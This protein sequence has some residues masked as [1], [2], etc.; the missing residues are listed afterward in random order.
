VQFYRHDVASTVKSFAWYVLSAVS[1]LDSMHAAA[2]QA[3][4]LVG[5]LFLG[6]FVGFVL[7]LSLKGP[8]GVPFKLAIG[9]IGAA[10]GATPLAFM[11][12]LQSERWMYPIGLVLGFAWLRIMAAR[13]EILKAEEEARRG[14]HR[15]FGK[16]HFAWIDTLVVIAATGACIVAAILTGLW[17]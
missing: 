15:R 11:R 10:L 7:A 12:D 4:V 9:V 5:V 17:L 2:M 1:Y 3:I 16:L 6:G 13:T 8:I 14:I